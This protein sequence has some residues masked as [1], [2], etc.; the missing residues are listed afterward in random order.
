MSDIISNLFSTTAV[1]FCPENKPFWYTSG[2]IGPYF[3][4][5]H[6]LYGSEKEATELLTFID[7]LLSN[8]TELPQKI[9]DKVLKQYNDNAIYKSVI[10]SMKEIIEKNIN[11]D[12]I[13]Y[14]SG[15][16]RR[17]WFFSNIIAYLLKKPHISIFKNLDCIISNY[18]FTE[19]TKVDNL[20]GKKVLHIADLV[21]TASS[22]VRAWIPVIEKLGAKMVWTSF[23]IDRMQGGSDILKNTGVQPLP[24]VQLDKS[25]FQQ[26]LD[27]HSINVEQQKMLN[28]YFDNPDETMKEFLINHPEFLENALNSDEKTKQRAKLLVEGNLYGLN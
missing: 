7:T 6:F 14:I 28:K 15:G 11:I 23:V 1:R 27:L 3:V 4:N 16:E 19:I 5:T 12:E 8:R 21:T 13:D 2:K 24:V 9:F 26:A 25:L 18:D 20:N 17:D 22:Y 10:N